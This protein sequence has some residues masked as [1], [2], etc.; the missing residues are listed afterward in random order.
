MSNGNL[1]K[2]KKIL[3]AICSSTGKAKILAFYTKKAVA[4]S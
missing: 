3:V 2:F 4:L 1:L